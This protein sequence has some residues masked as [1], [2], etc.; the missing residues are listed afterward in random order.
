MEGLRDAGWDGVVL[1]ALDGLDDEQVNSLVGPE[2]E[3]WSEEQRKE[4]MSEAKKRRITLDAEDTMV[5][6]R[7]KLQFLERTWVKQR[8]YA[9]FTPTLDQGRFELLKK[10]LPR[11]SWTTRLQKALSAVDN[12][13]QRA[14]LEN[15]ER[16]R[17]IGNM[18]KLLAEA[19]LISATEFKQ[20]KDKGGWMLRKYGVGR[21]GSTI[22]SYTRTG[23]KLV[24]FMKN[25]YGEPW[26]RDESEVIEYLVQRM[27]EPCG[28]SVPQTIYAAIAF[29]ELAAAI[30]LERRLVG[31]PAL[32]N[33]FR[34]AQSSGVW[35]SQKRISARRWPVV[36]P[37]GL[38]FVV[39][40]EDA[41]VYKR[42]FAWYK[43][44]KLWGALRWD[45]TLGCPPSSFRWVE[46]QGLEAEI[47]RSKTSGDGKRVESQKFFISVHSWL[48]NE[49]WLKTGL[50]LF[51]RTGSEANLDLRDF[52]LPK[53]NGNLSG[54]SNGIL[55]Y[56]DAMAMTR[57]MLSELPDL[58]APGLTEVQLLDPQVTAFWSEHTERV[59][60]ITW[61]ASMG[62]EKEVRQRWGR[63]RPTVDEEYAKTTGTMVREAQKMI[64]EGIR[65][66]HGFQDV[67]NDLEVL[68]ELTD[69]MV[70]KKFDVGAIEEQLTSLHPVRSMTAKAQLKKDGSL[71][72]ILWKSEPLV[73]VGYRGPLFRAQPKEPVED[74]DPPTPTSLI[75]DEVQ[76]QQVQAEAEAGRAE[77]PNGT[78]VMSV[79]G[80]SKR[81]TL[82]QVGAC[83]RRPGR[84]YKSFLVVGTR[85]QLWS[86]ERRPAEHAL[87]E[88]RKLWRSFKRELTCQPHRIHRLRNLSTARMSPRRDLSRS[89][90]EHGENRAVLL[91]SCLGGGG[92]CRLF[93]VFGC[94][95]S[96]VGSAEDH[97]AKV[98]EHLE[99]DLKKGWLVKMGLSEARRLYPGE[100]LQLAS[101]GAVPKDPDW[102]DIRV[103]HDGTHGI[104]LNKEIR[105]PN[106]MAFPQF[107]DLE[108]CMRTFRES[109]A[110]ER[111][112]LAFDI[113]AAHRLVP[114]RKEDWGRQGCR[115][116][117]EDVVYLNTRGTFG[118]ASA[119]FWWGRVAG[120]C[121]RV[122][123]RVMPRDSLFY[124]LLFAD[125]GLIL[126]GGPRY[127]F[128]VMAVLL[129]LEVME[130]PLSWRK[131]RGGFETEWIGYQVDL[132]AWTVG[133][134][135]KKVTWLASWVDR[136]VREGHV[137]GR[138]FRAGVGRMGFLAGAVK[139]AR[140]FLAP[141]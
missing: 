136:L 34:E 137:M 77:Y 15:E 68:T 134:S 18:V 46:T 32:V 17:W 101:L 31:R 139:A 48:V 49:T 89:Q 133:V 67:L 62:V 57:A 44:V 6:T 92:C 72:K 97:M 41:P 8:G 84:D 53:P 91:G 30:P 54:F 81:R 87:A 138:E 1:A 127:Q 74:L 120:T 35:R 71:E 52:M 112:L 9:S 61:A 86:E 129:F 10:A 108:A 28:K 55:K 75:L 140:P 65:S 39:M 13:G 123:R 27:E 141:M 19:E 98:E 33:F 131:C 100:G 90:R 12:F 93:V 99:E 70:E 96:V 103:V 80:R 119:A 132:K 121:F 29:M 109:E 37:M 116:S 25:I 114:V 51:W 66:H 95:R 47:V 3:N 36:I 125:D 23:R 113:K 7:K 64:C 5:A 59:T 78:Y 126:S 82:H 4:V 76:E 63:W 43:L 50:R 42:I 56:G 40:T 88:G 110:Q 11:M 102:G 122:L 73:D 106:R 60:M 128:Q 115:G 22:R 2:A 107:D 83:Y 26:F 94:R 79:V 118:V 14:K 45:D 69:W 24:F 21:R 124:L 38:E 16:D 85:G 104:A 130:M 135:D 20:V 117:K 105:Q 58:Q 111:F